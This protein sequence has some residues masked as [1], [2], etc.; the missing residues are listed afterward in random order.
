MKNICITFHYLQDCIY[1]Q[2]GLLGV[3]YIR[4]IKSNQQICFEDNMFGSAS[5]YVRF[6]IFLATTLSCTH[7][8]VLNLENSIKLFS[9]FGE[10]HNMMTTISAERISCLFC[11]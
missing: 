4:G 7:T 8:C 3:N 5:R 10:G 11:Y 9:L 2:I 6:V 1:F